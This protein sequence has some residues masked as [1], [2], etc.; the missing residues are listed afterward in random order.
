MNY[1]KK[2]LSQKKYIDTLILE[3][4]K[5]DNE[6]SQLKGELEFLKKYN[7]QSGNKA[8]ELISHINKLENDY[9]KEL[10]KL[11]KYREMYQRLC[12]ELKQAKK[13]IKKEKRFLNKL[14][15]K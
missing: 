2:Y 9:E 12:D 8:C 14:F 6:I 13:G 4:E 3:S 1:R 11:H 7:T 10:E 15:K 5:K